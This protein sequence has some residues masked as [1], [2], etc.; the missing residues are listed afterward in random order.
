M[1]KHNDSQQ[2]IRGLNATL[3]PNKSENWVNMEN[4]GENTSHL[5]LPAS[6]EREKPERIPIDLHDHSDEIDVLDVG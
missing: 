3:D 6:G 5:E 1:N 4:W 2:Q